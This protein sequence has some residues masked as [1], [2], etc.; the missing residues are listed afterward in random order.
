MNTL[1]IVTR[2]DKTNRMEQTLKTNE[3]SID[4]ATTQ[5]ITQHLI[6]GSSAE[7]KRKRND[8]TS[9]AATSKS[10]PRKKQKLNNSI[11][12]DACDYNS[13]DHDN[14]LMKTDT[15]NNLMNENNN[16]VMVSGSDNMLL[17]PK[18][19]ECKSNSQ[20]QTPNINNVRSV[21]ETE[22][23]IHISLSIITQYPS[24]GQWLQNMGYYGQVMTSNEHAENF[25]N[26]LISSHPQFK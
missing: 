10:P 18:Q 13:F 24:T 12:L 21:F 14:N 19:M 26:S 17:A 15:N 11:S 2:T 7:I 20:S 25:L 23:S 4:Q 5:K 22:N 9:T 1:N 8:D 6:Q 3:S 16:N